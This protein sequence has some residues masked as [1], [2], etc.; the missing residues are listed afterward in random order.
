[1]CIHLNV[2]GGAPQVTDGW[3][4][5]ISLRLDSMMTVRHGGKGNCGGVSGMPGLVCA[6]PR[7]I[8]GVAWKKIKKQKKRQEE[9]SEGV[10][11]L[12]VGICDRLK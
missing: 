11:C 4:A 12:L 2:L 6:F 8:M 7:I 10:K 5:P 1:M 3:A 9:W